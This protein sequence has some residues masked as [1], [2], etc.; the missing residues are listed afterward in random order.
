MLRD[1]RCI[2]MLLKSCGEKRGLDV[3]MAEARIIFYYG[4]CS[5]G[6]PWALTR[7]DLDGH[8]GAPVTEAV[9]VVNQYFRQR[10]NALLA[11]VEH[12]GVTLDHAKGLVSEDR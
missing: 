4:T 7:E 10:L 3:G 6:S 11:S 2:Q 1:L 8:F 12:A 5:V 9:E